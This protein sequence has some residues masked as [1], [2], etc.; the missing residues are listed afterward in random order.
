MFWMFA[1]PFWFGL[2]FI[3]LLCNIWCSFYET[4]IL[5]VKCWRIEKLNRF[6]NPFHSKV[7]SRYNFVFPLLDPICLEFSRLCWICHTFDICMSIFPT[8]KTFNN[9]CQNLMR[10]IL[11]L[12]LTSTYVKH[13]S[14]QEKQKCSLREG[15]EFWGL[16]FYQSLIAQ[17]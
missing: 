6:H 17:R 11:F 8:S 3:F 10:H 5:L 1:S 12:L 2:L 16:L 9:F 13:R 15:L 4:P 7:F 14:R